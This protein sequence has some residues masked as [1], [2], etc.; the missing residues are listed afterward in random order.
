MSQIHWSAEDP[1]QKGPALQCFMVVIVYSLNKLL[2]KLPGF[3]YIYKPFSVELKVES[4][5]QDP[6]LER[7]Y[8][9][10]YSLY[11]G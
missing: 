4:I 3:L 2:N 9:I 6:E 5:Q 1:P 8:R 11:M 7:E 10:L